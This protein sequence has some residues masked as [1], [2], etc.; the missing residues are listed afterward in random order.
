MIRYTRPDTLP[1]HLWFD[2][3]EKRFEMVNVKIT[4]LLHSFPPPAK[5]DDEQWLDDL[6]KEQ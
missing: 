6:F 2:W 1:D 3:I 5:G 4:P